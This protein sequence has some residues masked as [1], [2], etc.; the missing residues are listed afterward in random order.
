MTAA[1][2]A[3]LSAR[4]FINRKFCEPVRRKSPLSPLWASTCALM[5]RKK[6][7]QANDLSGCLPSQWVR[8]MVERFVQVDDQ[9]FAVMSNGELWAKKLSGSEWGRVLP[10]LTQIKAVAI[11]R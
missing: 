10:D 9:L 1:R 4:F 11:S 3:R 8:H 2:P 7:S 5:W 6:E